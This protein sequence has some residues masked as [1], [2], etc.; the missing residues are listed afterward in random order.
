ME[1]LVDVLLS[2]SLVA[3]AA[4]FLYWKLRA[5]PRRRRTIDDDDRVVLGPSLAKA[6]AKA[7]Q[8]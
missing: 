6:V 7:R 3:A 1:P 5:K 2:L 8:K 4:G